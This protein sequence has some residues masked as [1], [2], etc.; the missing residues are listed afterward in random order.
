MAAEKNPLLGQ[1]RRIEPPG[2]GNLRSHTDNTVRLL[3]E[4]ARA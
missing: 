2:R 1:G 4:M 3:R